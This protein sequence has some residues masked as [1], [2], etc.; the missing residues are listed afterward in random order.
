[1]TFIPPSSCNRTQ[2]VPD[3][4]YSHRQRTCCAS[5][6]VA[7]TRNKTFIFKS[8]SPLPSA[9]LFPLFNRP[10][11]TPAIPLF[12]AAASSFYRKLYP[13]SE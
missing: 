12:T 4:A 6:Y 1:M 9:A 11:L 5:H 7:A 13:S 8:P 10:L 2:P 3:L